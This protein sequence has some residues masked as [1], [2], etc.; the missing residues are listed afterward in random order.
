MLKS[1]EIPSKHDVWLH[2]INPP[3][4]P[5][6]VP[7]YYPFW[8]G[9]NHPTLLLNPAIRIRN[10]L[11]LR[12]YVMLCLWTRMYRPPILSPHIIVLLYSR[13]W[14]HVPNIFP[15]RPASWQ[16]WTIFIYIY[17]YRSVSNTVTLP[18]AMAYQGISHEFSGL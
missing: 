17:I 10:M 2:H 7:L 4:S 9:K 11:I 14:L 13:A 5:H 12:G 8:P 1:H 3:F 15:S 6:G 16:P 18:K